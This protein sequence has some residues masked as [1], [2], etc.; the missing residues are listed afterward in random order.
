MDPGT[1]APERS[2]GAT[3]GRHALPS[4]AFVTPGV[5]DRACPSS[6]DRTAASQYPRV[7]IRVRSR[8]PSPWSSL[9]GI[10]PG[11]HGQCQVPVAVLDAHDL[12]LPILGGV[13]PRIEARIRGVDDHQIVGVGHHLGPEALGPQ[14]P[15][16]VLEHNT[17]G[18]CRTL[19]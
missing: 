19:S 6:R 8:I 13:V 18:P 1:G 9:S 17:R 11:S 2:C 16:Q 3:L 14:L 5:T 7:S 10:G 4:G 15:D 12:D